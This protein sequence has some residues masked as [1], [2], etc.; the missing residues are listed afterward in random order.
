MMAMSLSFDS[1]TRSLM[2]ILSLL[3]FDAVFTHAR[4][5]RMQAEQPFLL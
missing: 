3:L 5:L 2:G 4:R 1:W